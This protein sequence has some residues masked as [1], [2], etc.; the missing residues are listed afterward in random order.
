MITEPQPH[1]PFNW[2]TVVAGFLGLLALIVL[3]PDTVTTQH[4]EDDQVKGVRVS[5]SGDGEKTPEKR[6]MDQEAFTRKTAQNLTEDM[7]KLAFQ[8]GLDMQGLRTVLKK[9]RWDINMALVSATATRRQIWL[10]RLERWLELFSL[11]ALVFLLGPLW[12]YWKLPKGPKRR[13]TAAKSI[14]YFVVTAAG[15]M[16][17]FN[18][19]ASVVVG[20]QEIQLALACF[21]TPKAAVTDAAIHLF[22]YGG[23]GEYLSLGELMRRGRELVAQDPMSALRIMEHLWAGLKALRDSQLIHWARISFWAA[24]RLVDLYGPFIFV[25]TLLVTYQVV[26]PVVRN[27]IQYPLAVI[28]EERDPSI[29]QFTKDQI[30]VLWRELKAATWTFGF[31]LL[32][33]VLSVVVVRLFTFPVV[34][35]ALKTL[36]ALLETL[37][38]KSVFADTGFL[39]SMLSV[40]AYLL[41]LC[42]LTL[43]P[44]GL[45]LSKTYAL[46]RHK[47][48][49]GARF[50]DYPLFGKALKWALLRILAPTALCALI[51]LGLYFLLAWAVDSAHTLVWL[52]APLFFPLLVVGLLLLRV[53]PSLWTLFRLDPR[54]SAPRLDGGD[55]G[56]EE[57]DHGGEHEGPSRP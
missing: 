19:V 4:K 57:C 2:K 10:H 21:G 42:G 14:P 40:A 25:A 37:V 28:R 26:S 11:I 53:F 15:A 8:G 5:C 18:G 17:V 47:V 55:D 56:G 1:L 12:L 46:V 48:A 41:C 34:L 30:K 49:H 3:V 35:V 54:E 16:A 50:R 39:L 51:P 20:L 31:I 7:A 27:V 13:A 6:Q 9:R 45:L 22:V 33:V 23:R 36:V 38:A 52:P 24:G 44:M 43:L 29:W 32:F